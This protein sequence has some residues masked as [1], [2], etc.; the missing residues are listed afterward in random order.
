MIIFDSMN[1][2]TLCRLILEF[3]CD[4][5]QLSDN[6]E[7]SIY[8]WISIDSGFQ[9]ADFFVFYIIEIWVLAKMTLAS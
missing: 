5:K 2:A 1:L 4:S 6:S 9:R 7:K 8:F 3:C